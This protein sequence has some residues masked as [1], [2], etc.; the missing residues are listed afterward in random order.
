MDSWKNQ[1]EKP[2]REGRPTDVGL[3]LNKRPAAQILIYHAL[4][5]KVFS[6]PFSNDLCKNFTKYFVFKIFL[7]KFQ[8]AMPSIPR[9]SLN[10]FQMIYANILQ[11]VLFSKYFLCK[12][13][14]TMHPLPRPSLNF[15]QLL[16]GNMLQ[17]IFVCKYCF[18]NIKLSFITQPQ[19]LLSTF[20]RCFLRISYKICSCKY[21][22]T[23]ID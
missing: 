13:Q 18:A 4:A 10:P 17:D 22:F 15:S 9:S 6:Q 16:Y 23:N 11:N 19:S 12:Y 1:A 5:P 20:P 7:C 14:F 3:K 2:S 8:F 21:R